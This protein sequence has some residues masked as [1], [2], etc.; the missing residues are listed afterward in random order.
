[1]ADV[2]IR[3]RT[4]NAHSFDDAL[5]AVVATGATVAV[6]WGVTRFLQVGDAATGQPVLEELFARYAQ[7]PGTIDLPALWKRLGIALEGDKVVYDDGAPLADVRRA[8][9]KRNFSPPPT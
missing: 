5:R 9:T 4:K 2:E 6:S 3:S 7:A 8:I 1:M